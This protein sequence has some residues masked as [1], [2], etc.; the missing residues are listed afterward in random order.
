MHTLHLLSLRDEGLC[1]CSAKILECRV[2]A[3]NS[4]DIN[5]LIESLNPKGI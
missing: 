2:L 5:E 3:R 1:F 4:L